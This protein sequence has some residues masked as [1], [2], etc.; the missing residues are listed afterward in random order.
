M[1]MIQKFLTLIAIKDGTN[2][3]IIKI[4]RTSNICG[5]NGYGAKFESHNLKPAKRQRYFYHVYFTSNDDEIKGI[6][7]LLKN[8]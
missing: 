2:Y 3:K 6:N 4:N 7:G 5:T 8:V 1:A